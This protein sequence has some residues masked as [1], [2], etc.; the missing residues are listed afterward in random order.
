MTARGARTLSRLFQAT[1]RIIPEKGYSDSVEDASPIL[2]EKGLVFEPD[3]S[4]KEDPRIW[5][6]HTRLVFKDGEFLVRTLFAS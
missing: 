4:P 1:M 2:G 5:H 3:F 6:Y